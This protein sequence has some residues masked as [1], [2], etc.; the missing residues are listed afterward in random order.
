[1]EDVQRKLTLTFDNGTDQEVTPRVLD[2]VQKRDLPEI[3]F[4]AG[5]RLESQEARDLVRM[6]ADIR[7]KIGNHTYSHPRPF[8]A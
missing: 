4:P 6:T 8:G 2:E 3:F 1:M 5:E 7:H